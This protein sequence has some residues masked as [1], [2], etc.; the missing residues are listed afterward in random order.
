[1]NTRL[2]RPPVQKA[3]TLSDMPV[4]AILEF[5]YRGNGDHPEQYR[6]V[7]VTEIRDNG[8]LAEDTE[9]GGTKMFLNSQASNIDIVDDIPDT[10]W[11][12]AYPGSDFDIRTVN[13]VDARQQICDESTLDYD[14]VQSLSG[15]QL[16]K[17]YKAVNGIQQDVVF[18]NGV[19]KVGKQTHNTTAA[20]FID[21]IE[22]RLDVTDPLILV[23]IAKLVGINAKYIGEDIFQ[24][25]QE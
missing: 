14:F 22:N 24:I 2:Q 7:Q 20:R 6:H 10:S 1:M 25:E 19:L 3:R 18:D 12:N 17:L 16:A 8:I 11:R 15:E 9:Y 23:E 5:W 4:G 21:Y 13:F